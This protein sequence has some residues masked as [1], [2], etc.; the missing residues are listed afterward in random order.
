MYLTV[1]GSTLFIET[2][3]RHT[4]QDATADSKT[5]PV[6]GTLEITGHLGDVMKESCKIALT[7]ARNELHEIE[8]SN[9][10]LKTNHIHLHVPEVSFYK[11]LWLFNLKNCS[12]YR[13]VR[14]ATQYILWNS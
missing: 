12:H 14:Q 5:P 10:F 13:V 6:P 9:N 3:V 2:S 7:V 4:S 11:S 1:G 8:A